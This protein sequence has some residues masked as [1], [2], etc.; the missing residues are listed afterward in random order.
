MTFYDKII[1]EQFARGKNDALDLRS[2]SADMDGTQIIAEELKIPTFDPTKDY[3]SWSVGSPVKELLD[4]EYQVFKLLQPHNA[5][6]YTGTPSTL[7][8]LW[9]I[10]H[11]TDPYKAKPYLAPNGT[12]GMYMKDEC[13]IENNE[14]FRSLVDD[15]VYAPS[16]YLDNWERVDEI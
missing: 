11:T 3:L 12:S 7:P 16:A 2:R 4:G 15:N 5:S 13:C 8:A 1:K 14:V 6:H 9:S 10:C